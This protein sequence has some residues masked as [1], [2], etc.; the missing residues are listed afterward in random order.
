MSNICPLKYNIL[1][2][3]KYKCI[4]ECKKDEIYKYNYKN[5]CIEKCPKNTK[6]DEINKECLEICKNNQIEIDNACY[7]DLSN[8]TN[9]FFQNGYIFINNNSNF[10]ND[11]LLDII[12]SSY[13]PND[14]KSLIIKGA[15]NII[16]QVTNSKNELELLKNNKNNNNF[17][18]IDL[19]ECEIKLKTKY[20]INENDSLI[21]IK[22]EKIASKISEKNVDFDVYEP[23]NKTKLNL[24]VCDDTPFNLIFPMELN[25]ENK[26]LYEK[27]KELGYDMFNINDPFYQDICIPYDSSNGTDILLID[28]INYIYNNDDTKCQSNCHF[29]FYSMET[30]YINCSCSTIEKNNKIDKFTAKKLYQMFYDDIQTMIY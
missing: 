17:S 24:S 2:N 16:L 15:D 1:I 29:S 9:L 12:L 22:N 4:D 25:E 11:L 27:M 6:I 26:K 23:Y 8:I 19:G 30:K 5:I 20:H 10:D 18:I 13:I 28:R 3:Q 21:F 7:N 14:N